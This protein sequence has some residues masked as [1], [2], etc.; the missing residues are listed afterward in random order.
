MMVAIC[1]GLPFS[2][3]LPSG[4]LLL[5]AGAPGGELVF[6]WLPPWLFLIAAGALVA[7]TI[8]L[9]GRDRQRVAGWRGWALTALRGA[10]MLLLLC[11]LLDMA[12]IERRI[13]RIP[14]TVLL[15]VDTSAS[16]GL[17]DDHR[18]PAAQSD[19]AAALGIPSVGGLSRIDRVRSAL[20][21][22]WLDGL[23]ARHRIAVATVDETSRL[24]TDP[25]APL[26]SAEPV[27]TA[28]ENLAAAGSITNLASPLVDLALSMP[29]SRLAGMILFSDGNHRSGDDPRR[30]AGMLA[31]LGVPIVA[32]GVGADDHPDDVAVAGV[33]GV[34]RVFTGDEIELEAQITAWGKPARRVPVEVR[35][36]ETTAAETA[37]DLPP[38]GGTAR[39][40]IRIPAGAAGRRRIT[41]SIPP[42][43]DEATALNN[44][45]DVWIDV[46][47]EEARVLYLESGARWE[48]H[49]LHETWQR[50]EATRLESFLITPPPESRL[51]D[52]FPRDAD[53]LFEFDVVV[54]GDVSPEHFT[55]RGR[56]M[57]AAFVVS[58]GGALLL[59]A[60]EDHM[61]YAW[62][63]TP[64]EP[65]LPVSL[66]SPAPPPDLGR[67]LARRGQRLVLT[68]EGEASPA[69]R[70][71]AGRES[72][73]DL[74]S[75][76]PPQRWFCPVAGGRD[77]S[78]DLVQVEVERAA[79]GGVP[80]PSSGGAAGA[81]ERVRIPVLSLREQGAGRVIYSGID[82]T[83][84]WR[85][86]QGVHLFERFWKL[87]LRSALLERLQA[88]D[89]HV[90]LGTDRVV[91][92]GRTEIAIR[93]LITSAELRSAAEN[94]VDA[95]VRI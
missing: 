33:E 78:V 83:W 32:I 16:M 79:I 1:A 11:V 48:Y 4:A 47:S 56:E 21:S 5:A 86:G 49:Y 6:R 15:V 52:G 25:D 45:K 68:A 34:T 42:Q 2:A 94:L 44:R 39:S 17:G 43:P 84:R 80:W 65:L 14:S 71:A 55:Q 85:T 59:I 36:G 13:E 31:R 46:V 90:W 41:I 93:A 67:R 19:E 24:L 51:P 7:S 75:R 87:L 27:R 12:W 81:D 72:N 37:V 57:L 35:D 40:T 76:L 70:L 77:G 50:D 64:L 22:P 73:F 53:A 92:D 18:S 26:E 29:R 9:Y 66:V 38:G 69:C 60:G 54:I 30:A 58:R 62:A 74:W 3:M 61:P 91:T 95:V 10:S 89:D 82:A 8:R 88:R 23:A 28:L 20:A 63:G